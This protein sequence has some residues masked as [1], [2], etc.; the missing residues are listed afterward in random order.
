MVPLQQN[1]SLI[2]EVYVPHGTTPGIQE[3]KL[4][5]QAGGDV[6]EI[7]VALEIRDFTL[8]DKLSFVP[9]MNAYGTVNPFDGYD[10]YRLAHRHR[11]WDQPTSA[12]GLPKIVNCCTDPFIL[13]NRAVPTGLMRPTPILWTGA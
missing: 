6:L 7:D 8:P 13:Q 9:E 2:C 3:G 11:T 10:Y 4:T 5:V 12:S 1:L